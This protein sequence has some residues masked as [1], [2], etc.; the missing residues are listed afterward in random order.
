MTNDALNNLYERRSVRAYKTEQ[1]SKDE[2]DA[3]LKAG[4]C[5]PSA[6]N[7]QPT[8]M[9]VVQDKETIALLSKLNAQV[10][11]R[12][13]DPF[14]AAPTVI[15]VLA[16]RTVPTHI[17]DGS[18]VLGNLMNAAN[19]LGLG[20]CWINR[21]R[22]VFE[23]PEA[24]EILRKKGIGDKYIGIGHCVLGYP[25]GQSQQAP[26]IREDRVYSIRQYKK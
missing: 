14:Y 24:R 9:L 11:G 21:A 2:L 19:A 20:S 26:P 4:L 15:V 10:M 1:I 16:D 8:V 6:M 7:R 3:V 22:E 13:I 25:A 23:M 18:L 5:A 17:E 12:D